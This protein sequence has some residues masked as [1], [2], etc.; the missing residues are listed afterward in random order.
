MYALVSEGTLNVT[1][2]LGLTGYDYLFN[3]SSIPII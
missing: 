3:Y 1:L 2:D